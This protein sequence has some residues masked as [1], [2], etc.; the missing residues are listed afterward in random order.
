VLGGPLISFLPA[1]RR[2]QLP[3]AFHR[4]PAHHQGHGVR[5]C[6]RRANQAL[7]AKRRLLGL[8]IPLSPFF[9]RP[10]VRGGYMKQRPRF[11][12]PFKTQSPKL[13]PRPVQAAV[14]SRAS[15]RNGSVLLHCS[16]QDVSPQVAVCRQGWWHTQRVETLHAC[17]MNLSRG[18]GPAFS[19]GR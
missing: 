10:L 1:P 13:A 8:H 7:S 5:R 14:L 11:L 4:T 12:A 2:H 19:A 16:P 18:V 9:S 15:S 3:P 6:G 17:R